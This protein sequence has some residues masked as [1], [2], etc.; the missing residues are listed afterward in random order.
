MSPENKTR[1]ELLRSAP[2]NKWIAL[3]PDESEIVA[4]GD[5]F[6]EVSDQSDLAGVS[7]PLILKTPEQW[8]PISV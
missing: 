5:T 2:L 1:L 6:G 3:S 4:I 7:D 8:A